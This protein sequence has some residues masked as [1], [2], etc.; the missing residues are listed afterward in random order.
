MPV[1]IQKWMDAGYSAQSSS[2]IRACKTLLESAIDFSFGEVLDTEYAD[3]DQLP[4]T[5]K[6]MIHGLDERQKGWV[7]NYF[8]IKEPGES[9]SDSDSDA[10]SD[11]IS[12]SLI[13]KTDSQSSN[14]SGVSESIKTG[15]SNAI[16]S[17]FL[18]GKKNSDVLLTF[19]CSH[20]QERGYH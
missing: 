20:P 13:T 9:S 14:E 2:F 17:E 19:E 3:G 4:T 16:E 10:W 15:V 5:L 7:Y 1:H 6:E 8:L 12:L 18:F 11:Q